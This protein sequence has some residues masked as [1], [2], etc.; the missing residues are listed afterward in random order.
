MAHS[1]CFN[2][3][4]E[5]NSLSITGESESID[6]V[7]TWRGAGEAS[8]AAQSS[9]QTS[10][11]TELIRKSNDN[12]GRRLKAR[13]TLMNWGERSSRKKSDTAAQPNRYP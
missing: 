4:F 11:R 1:A 10:S 12:T 2:S 6:A 8:T 5:W 9:G 3:S 13:T 7:T